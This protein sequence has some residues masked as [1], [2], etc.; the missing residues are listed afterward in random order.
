MHFQKKVCSLKD[1]FPLVVIAR[2]CADTCREV[3]RSQTNWSDEELQNE[4]KPFI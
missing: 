3:D 1:Y 2:M 4:G